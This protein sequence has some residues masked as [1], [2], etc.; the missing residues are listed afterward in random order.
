MASVSVL[1]LERNGSCHVETSPVSSS[2][3]APK[4]SQTIIQTLQTSHCLVGLPS[5]PTSN[6]PLSSPLFP[7]C[8]KK[9]RSIMPSKLATGSSVLS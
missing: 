6:P 1:L 4:S 3:A 5:P 2:P 7:H 8:C 9:T